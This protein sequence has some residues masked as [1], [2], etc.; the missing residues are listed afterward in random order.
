MELDVNGRVERER[1]RHRQPDEHGKSA[2]PLDPAS[3][4]ATVYSS[5]EEK[6]G[7]DDN[8]GEEVNDSRESE[9]ALVLRPPGIRCLLLM[10]IKD[11]SHQEPTSKD[12]DHPGDDA[13]QES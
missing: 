11:D 2:G 8:A 1:H 4:D 6:E 10:T 9:A 13:G 5:H 3:E 7:G 12:G